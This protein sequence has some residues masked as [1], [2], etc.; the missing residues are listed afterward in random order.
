MPDEDDDH[1]PLDC[2]IDDADPPD[3]IAV[4]VWEIMKEELPD[5][6]RRMLPRFGEVDDKTR[7]D[8]LQLIKDFFDD[9]NDREEEGVDG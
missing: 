6:R 8:F 7:R 4:K 3:R 9:L 5:R 2:D 1:P